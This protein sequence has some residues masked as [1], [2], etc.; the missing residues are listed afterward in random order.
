MT[1]SSARAAAGLTQRP[2]KAAAACP[3]RAVLCAGQVAPFFEIAALATAGLRRE[4]AKRGRVQACGGMRGRLAFYF[5]RRTD[6]DR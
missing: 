4:P 2:G 5:T 6:D 3:P 1:R